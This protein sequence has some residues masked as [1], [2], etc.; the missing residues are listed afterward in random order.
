MTAEPEESFPTYAELTQT[1]AWAGGAPVPIAMREAAFDPGD[2]ASRYT[3]QAVLGVGGMGKVVLAHDARIGRDVAVKQLRSDRDMT[4]DERARFLREAQVQGQLEHPSIVPVYDIDHRP[5]GTTF[6]TMR[7]V[8]GRT[9]HDIIHDLRGGAPD[10]VA[11][12]TQ[13]ELLQ[14]FGTVCLAVDYAHSRGVI[15][16]DLKPSNI[17]LGNFGEVYVLD[18]G[19][20][21]LLDQSGQRPGLG[22]SGAGPSEPTGPRERLS[23]TGMGLGTPLYMAPEQMGDPD[24]DAAADVF[25]LG[26]VLFEILTLQRLRTTGMVVAPVDAQISVRMPDRPVALELELLC[27]RATQ[28]DPADRFPS[29]RALHDALAR[30]L[31]GD[32]ELEQRR[33]L[34]AGHAAR[35]R[36]ALRRAEEPAARNT[37]Q[38]TGIAMRELARALALEPANQEHVAAFAEVMSAQPSAV[39]PELSAR[40]EA[41]TQS[42][43]RAGA[44]YTGFG[45]LV[46]LL[47][48]PILVALGVRRVDHV[49]AIMAPLLLSAALSFTAARQRPIRRPI[50]CAALGAMLLASVGV[51]RIVGPLFL[52]P[53][54]FTSWMIVM[55]T[56]PDG[57]MRR[58]GLITGALLMVAPVVLELAGVLPSSYTFEGGKLIVLPQMMELPRAGTFAF[59]TL[60]NVALG[61]APAIFVARLRSEL[62]GAQQRELLRAWRLRRLPEEL[63]RANPR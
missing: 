48:L 37:E 46:W 10:A 24:V 34:A 53:T 18:W 12:Y 54:L 51:S 14:A 39:P 44:R 7:R 38:D 47:F 13:R 30:Y 9:L 17:M 58:F 4:S 23:M 3:E 20:A 22:A 56:S 15:H 8:L 6:F 21:R 52:M 57:F 43:I 5:D 16:R 36:A 63:M 41:Q 35:A 40:L 2:S 55:Q 49:L 19:V 28:H 29:A 32:R 61:L 59:V 31:E 42:V 45:V 25:A 27:V 33:E 26:A 60:A 62:T 1:Q 11:R 50:Q